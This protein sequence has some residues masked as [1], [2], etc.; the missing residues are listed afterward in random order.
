[1]VRNVVLGAVPVGCS[2]YIDGLD[3]NMK[4][5]ACD[6]D[7]VACTSEWLNDEAMKVLY[8]CAEHAPEDAEFF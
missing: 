2:A 1:M 7:A 3:V 6:K 8:W 5:E 4:C